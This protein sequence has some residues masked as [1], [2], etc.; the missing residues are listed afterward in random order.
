MRNVT[1][2]LDD[3]TARWARLEAARRDVSVSRLLRD[4]VRH[5]MTGHESYDA[6]MARFL[7]RPVQAISSGE[8]YPSRESLHDRAPL[9]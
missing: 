6:A 7:S 1:V 9:R 4:L 5:E 3:E 8:R 2:T